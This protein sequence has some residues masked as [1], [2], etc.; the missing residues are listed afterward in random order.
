M[1]SIYDKPID[2]TSDATLL[3]AFTEACTQH[4]LLPDGE[5]AS[6]LATVLSHAFERGITSEDG[7]IA[8]VM[9]LTTSK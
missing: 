8:L 4:G 5:D 1:T 9:N 2:E 7:L 3:A 6:D